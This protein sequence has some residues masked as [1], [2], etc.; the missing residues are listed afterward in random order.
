MHIIRVRNHCSDEGTVHTVTSCA[1]L[2]CAHADLSLINQKLSAKGLLVVETEEP[3][4]YVYA[5]SGYAY[6]PLRQEFFISGP[7]LEYS[8]SP[9]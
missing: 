9:F 6:G 2:A 3:R 7:M 1:D 8:E 5:R 4:L